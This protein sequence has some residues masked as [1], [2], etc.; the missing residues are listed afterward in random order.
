MQ[1]KQKVYFHLHIPRCAGSSLDSTLSNM[2][3]RFEKLSFQNY[4][5]FWSLLNRTPD[6]RSYRY[7][8]GH[9]SYGLHQCF[10]LKERQAVYILLLR[11]PIARVISL[12]HYH[13]NWPSSKLY[14]LLNTQNMSIASFFKYWPDQSV[15]FS[16]GQTR[17]LCDYASAGL[18][19]L[20]E[21]HLD[22]AVSVIKRRHSVVGIQ[23]D[24]PGF[25]TSLSKCLGHEITFPFV[26]SL[27]AAD[28]EVS[29]EDVE[30]IRINNALDI[31]LYQQARTL[32]VRDGMAA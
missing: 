21:I 19:S 32:H 9:F 1:P 10:G 25:Q 23:E 22:S 20:S 2:F 17:Q 14:R 12:Y 6:V 16:N 27:N 30:Q 11:D 15:Q 28:V 8:S 29:E 4:D 31:A 18:L 24:M 13:R 3:E 7:V 5:Q 26:N